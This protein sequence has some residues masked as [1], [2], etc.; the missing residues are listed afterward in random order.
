MEV[1]LNN[2]NKKIPRNRKRKNE[3]K[4]KMEKNMK[5][6]LNKIKT[7]KKKKNFDKV[8]QLEILLVQIKYG[9]N[10][11]VLENAS[12]ELNKI[13]VVIKNLYEIKQ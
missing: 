3:R 9:D 1:I 11:N 5:L 4:S 6:F 10:P 2:E 8:K 7:E 12:K 13:Q